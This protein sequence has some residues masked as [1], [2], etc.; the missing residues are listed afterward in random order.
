M[1]GEAKEKIHFES[2]WRLVHDKDQKVEIVYRDNITR[3]KN[4][5]IYT[6]ARM[7][8]FSFMFNKCAV[9]PDFTTKPFFYLARNMTFYAIQLL[10]VTCL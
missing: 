7:K 1:H 5:L 10:F 6:T 4:Q 9:F 3:N 8:I 2:M